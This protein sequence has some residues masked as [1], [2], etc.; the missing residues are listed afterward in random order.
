MEENVGLA[1][2]T[3]THSPTQQPTEGSACVTRVSVAC[4]EDLVRVCAQTKLCGI[5]QLRVIFPENKT[6]FEVV[7]MWKT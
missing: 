2:Q 6:S 5:T 7:K 1:Q 4:P 3:H